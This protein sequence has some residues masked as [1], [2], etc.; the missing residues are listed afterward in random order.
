MDSGHTTGHTTEQADLSAMKN[1]LVQYGCTEKLAGS[2]VVLAARLYRNYDRSHG[3]PH[4]IS[5]LK[6]GLDF[7]GESACPDLAVII[8]IHDGWDQKYRNAWIYGES[9]RETVEDFI[10]DYFEDEELESPLAHQ[11]SNHDRRAAELCKVVDN[12]SF[13]AEL[14]SSNR[15]FEDPRLEELRLNAQLADWYTSVGRDGVVKSLEYNRALNNDLCDAVRKQWVVRFQHYPAV[16][17][18]R[19]SGT[20]LEKFTTAVGEMREIIF[21]GEL[22]II[23]AEFLRARK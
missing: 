1:L 17:A 9:T 14:K 19:T 2:L 15:V 10:R 12:M 21:G 4:I 16:V 20:A 6:N 11:P 23:I 3:I 7:A 8:T 22:Q 18:A 5:V 13:S